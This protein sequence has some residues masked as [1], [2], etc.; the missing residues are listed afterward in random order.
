MRHFSA[1]GI[2][3]RLGIAEMKIYKRPLQAFFLSAP[4]HSR[5]FSWLA[6]LAINEEL[7]GRLW[8]YTTKLD[9]YFWTSIIIYKDMGILHAVRTFRK[10]ETWAFATGAS[11][12]LWV[13]SLHAHNDQTS[14]IGLK[15]LTKKHC[16]FQWRD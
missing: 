11:S 14:H 15:L 1:N 3:P 6:T 16:V 7:C 2:S 13:F 5:V 4:P 12:S 10:R 8:T 9:H